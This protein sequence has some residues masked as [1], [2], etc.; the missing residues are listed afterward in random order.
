M[1]TV[2]SELHLLFY[3]FLPSE[4]AFLCNEIFPN[5]PDEMRKKIGVCSSLALFLSGDFLPRLRLSV[6]KLYLPIEF[7]REL[8]YFHSGIN[9]Y[10]NYGAKYLNISQ[11]RIEIFL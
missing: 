10:I 1:S 8:F 7:P 9:I 2:R 11:T 3:S 4:L 6:E 5:I